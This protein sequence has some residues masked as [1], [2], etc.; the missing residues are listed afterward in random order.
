MTGRVYP[1]RIKKKL[2]ISFP[3]FRMAFDGGLQGT[4]TPGRTNIEHA[5]GRLQRITY[6]L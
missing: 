6:D 1:S 4:V 2:E 3:P 5:K